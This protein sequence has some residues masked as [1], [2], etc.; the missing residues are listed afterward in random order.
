M[1]LSVIQEKLKTNLS[2][3]KHYHQKNEQNKNHWNF[4]KLI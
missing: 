2:T 4:I 3:H 1:M